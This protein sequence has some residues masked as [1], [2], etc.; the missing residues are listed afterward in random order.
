MKIY[1]IPIAK[2]K[3]A[4]H[5]HSLYKPSGLVGK[6]INKATDKWDLLSKSPKDSFKNKFFI[7]SSDVL[8]KIDSHEWF[9]KSVPPFQKDSP[10][11][12]VFLF[13]PFL[14]GMDIQNTFVG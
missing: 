4:Y 11:S 14:F 2:G 12:K 8:D 6:L 7:W 5:C 10:P 3:I 1:A 9:L 13:I